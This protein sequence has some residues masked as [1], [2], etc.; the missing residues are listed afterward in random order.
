MRNGRVAGMKSTP[1]STP[2]GQ[3]TRSATSSGAGANPSSSSGKRRAD[4]PD[5]FPPPLHRRTEEGPL[6]VGV[7]VLGSPPSGP[8][9]PLCQAEREM[10]GI[11]TQLPTPVARER[12]GRHQEALAHALA[13]LKALP[14]ADTLDFRQIVAQELQGLL[15]KAGFDAGLYAARTREAGGYGRYLLHSDPDPKERFCLQ[16]F[17]FDPRQKTPI[18]NHP[19]ECAS[20][21]A[22]GA[23][24]ERV[25]ELPEAAAD[26]GHAGQVAK[27]R[28]DNRPQASWAGFDRTDLQVPHSLKNHGNSMAVSVHLYRDMDGVSERQ[29]V[30]AA[31]KFERFKP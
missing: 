2:T 21:I 28:K 24:M 30:A 7:A 5:G 19:N 6:R 27:L 14:R 1:L 10:P 22:Q 8:L 20:Y 11:Y 3:P 23:L 17:A 29:Q 25:Y 15:Q 12:H 4:N 26:A 9:T 31:D 16:I 13:D 18:H